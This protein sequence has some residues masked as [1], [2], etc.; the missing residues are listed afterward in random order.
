MGAAG[1]CSLAWVGMLAVLC[2]PRVA[3][4][5]D[6]YR[7]EL[8]RGEGAGSCPGA[9]AL[10]R[11]VARRLGRDPFSASAERGIE[12]VIERAEGK[13]RARLFLRLGEA[14]EDAARSLESEAPDCE[15]LSKAVALSVALAIAPELPPLP[16]PPPPSPPKPACPAA[17]LIA[18][19]PPKATLHGALA[20]R[21]AFSPNLLPQ[22]VFG[23]AL[24]M[25][26][27]GELLGANVGGYFYPQQQLESAGARL[28]FGLSTAFAS[29]CLWPRTREPQ[30]WSCLGAQLGA[31]HAVV[32]SPAPERP[33]DR[34]WLAA[35]SELG[36]RQAVFGRVFVE[37]GAAAFFPLLRQRFAI[38]SEAG[39][40]QLAYEQ[41]PAVVEGFLG[42]GLR[43]D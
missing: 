29:A 43:L 4:A 37:G 25:T 13:W 28:G 2:V 33:G 1:I 30:V 8:V 16:P 23:A 9:A 41:R 3:S 31:L 24:S 18:P 6:G 42:L 26:L 21:A 7:L 38:V 20:L 5:S 19:P 12:I 39:A 11:E 17:I 14:S 34:V 32:F 10:E 40:A 15:E 35:S 27:R 36:V 22:P